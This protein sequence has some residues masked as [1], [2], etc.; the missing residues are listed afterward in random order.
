MSLY[1]EGAARRAE[2]PLEWIY[3]SEKAA[4][5]FT[6]IAP[7]FFVF[8]CLTAMGMFFTPTQRGAARDRNQSAGAV[9]NNRALLASHPLQP[10]K[11]V[12]RVRTALIMAAIVLI[13]AGV[14]NGSARDVFYKAVKICTECIGLG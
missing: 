8:L 10:G 13:V 6:P 1:R 7:I 11:T 2:H 5:K 4:E 9:K 14:L 12:R 3:T